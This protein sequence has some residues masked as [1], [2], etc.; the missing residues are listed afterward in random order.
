[1]TTSARPSSELPLSARIAFCAPSL[2]VIVTNPKPRER[3]VSR[4]VMIRASITSPWAENSSVS[5]ASV[6]RQG[7]LPT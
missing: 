1:L 6:A 2:L 7:R 3:P 5:W 4:S